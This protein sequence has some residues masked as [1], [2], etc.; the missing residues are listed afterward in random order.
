MFKVHNIY[1]NFKRLMSHKTYVWKK[2]HTH[3]GN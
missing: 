2:K 1:P 3:G